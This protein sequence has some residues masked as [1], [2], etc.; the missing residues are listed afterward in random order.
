LGNGFVDVVM[1]GLHG[2]CF[3]YFYYR[4]A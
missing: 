3:G 1:E 2:F 4:K